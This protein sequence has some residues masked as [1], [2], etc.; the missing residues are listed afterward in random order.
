M[1]DLDYQA[2]VG[3]VRRAP[4]GKVP[5]IDDDGDIIADSSAIIDHLKKRYGDPLDGELDASQRALALLMQRTME[6]HTY[7]AIGYLRW[8]SDTAWP[9]LKAVF[10]PMLPRMLMALIL[11]AIRK[12]VIKSFRAQGMGRHNKEEIL[13]RMRRDLD[14]LTEFLG[15]QPFFLG[16][17]PT[18]I[19]AVMYGFL[20]QVLETP[21][22][23][24]EKALVR[25]YKPLLAFTDRMKERYWSGS[26]SPSS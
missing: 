16:D 5:W 3:D 19:D 9:H 23:S 21:W 2:E 13:G 11:P 4:K 7:F 1:A 18:S 14:S 25:E 6:E 15:D 26:E 8:A 17:E 12:S 24:E 10:A 22:D 20:P